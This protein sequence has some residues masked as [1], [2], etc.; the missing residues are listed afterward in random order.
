MFMTLPQPSGGFEWTQASW[1]E[2][3]TCRPLAAV[4]DHLFTVGNLQLRDDPT[5]WAAVAASI[6]VDLDRLLLI[7]QVHGAQV[8][9]ARRGRI[10]PWERPEGDVIVSDD[11]ASAIGIRIADCAPILLAD[12]RLQ[13]VAAAHAGWRGTAQEAAGTAVRAMGAEF[14]SHP[15]D[16][17]AAIGPCLGPC[18]GEVGEE[19]VTAFRDAGHGERSLGR[20][21]APGPSGR[22]FLDLWSANRDQLEAAGVP[23]VNIHVA[24]LCTRTHATVLHSY[25]MAREKAGRMAAVIRAGNLERRVTIGTAASTIT[26]G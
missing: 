11:P 15:R 8:A 25:R 13:V 12:A 7:R 4:A 3:L 19:V 20:W 6:G 16:V 10:D 26:S 18:C 21:F 2:A 17:V 1:G 23:A 24:R 5:E 22:A 14:G 9:I